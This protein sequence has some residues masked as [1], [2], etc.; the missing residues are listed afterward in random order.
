[1]QKVKSTKDFE[2][3]GGLNPDTVRVNTEK[4]KAEVV[5]ARCAIPNPA[6]A[7]FRLKG[8]RP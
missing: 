3:F 6:T 8:L 7:L 2:L 4:S 5:L 1:V